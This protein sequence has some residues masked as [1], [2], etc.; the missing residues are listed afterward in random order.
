MDMEQIKDDAHEDGLAKGEKIGME[1]GKIEIAKK[2]LL[3]G[4]DINQ[5]YNIT[6]LSED[7]LKKVV[8][9]NK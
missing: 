6:G 1:K 3:S 8:Q 9:N 2:L 7:D 5:V 4:M